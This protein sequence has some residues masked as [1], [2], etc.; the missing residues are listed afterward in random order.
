L[1]YRLPQIWLWL[2]DHRI[3][4]YFSS[5]T[6]IDYMPQTWGLATLPFLQA[7]GDKLV[8][9]WTFC[10]WLAFYLVIYDWSWNL[11]GQER[12]SQY[13]AFFASS[14]TFAVLQAT[15]SAND[16]FAATGLV[17]A[18]HFVGNF[19]RSRDG[20]EINWSVLSFALACGTKTHYAI[21]GLPLVLWF[22]LS[23][24]KPWQAFHWKWSLPLLAVWLL[25]SP[26]P[27]FSLN[28]KAS[29]SLMG[30]DYKKMKSPGGP[31]WN[32]AVGTTMFLLQ[33]SPPPVNPAALVLNRR[34]EYYSTNSCV[35]KYVPKFSLAMNVVAMPDSAGLGIVAIGLM[36]AGA[37]VAFRQRLVKLKSLPGWAALSGVGLLLAALSQFVPGGTART[38]SGFLF[39]TLPLVILGWNLLGERSLRWGLW[40]SFLSALTAIVMEP[41]RPLWP[42]QWTYHKLLDSQRTARFAAKLDSYFRIPERAHAGEALVQEGDDWPLL[43]LFRP[44]S[45][46]RDVL[47]IPLHS[48]SKKLD[49]LGVNYV[50]VGGGGADYYP[51]LCRYLDSEGG[52][53]KAIMTRQ[54]VS[55][56]S[57]GAEPWTLYRRVGPPK[58]RPD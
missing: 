38:Y 57:R 55:R 46:G 35:R 17:L 7:F 49:E 25:C 51:E 13:L 52:A 24:A 43:P 31:I 27:S 28:K 12:K 3:L 37:V 1:T 53:F 18:L 33:S 4:N 50:I 16:L 23:P 56:V 11:N 44:Y 41:S 10:G 54:Y 48:T 22:C 36:V 15:S 19:E 5:N 26:V 40:L 6:R 47:L 32:V 29:G 8:W 58:S 21:F 34:L 30:R 20:R 45:L 14:S 9:F 42:A 39:L 2:Q